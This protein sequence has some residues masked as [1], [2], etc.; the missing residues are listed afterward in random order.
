MHRVG[1]VDAFKSISNCPDVLSPSAA[2]DLDEG[3]SEFNVEGGVD[4]GV[5][6]AVDITQPG[7]S[8]VKPRRHVACPAVGVQNVSHKERQPADEKHPWSGQRGTRR[9][10]GTNEKTQEQ[11]CKK[12][13][14]CQLQMLAC[15]LI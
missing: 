14:F 10:G 9:E 12:H 3:P 15:S 7:E 11:N 8:T 5:E 2:E 13:C 6:G 4:Y 1:V